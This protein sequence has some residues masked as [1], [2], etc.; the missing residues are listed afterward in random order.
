[1]KKGGGRQK[2]SKFER[3]CAKAIIDTFACKGITAEDCYRTPGSGGHR[4]A[5]KTDP[6]DLV[7]SRR[8][9]KLWPYAVE[10]KFY[11][12]VELRWLMQSNVKEGLFSSWWAQAV[13]ATP[14]D[15]RALLVF[16]QNRD[17]PYAMFAYPKDAVGMDPPIRP[18]IL[19]RVNGQQVYVVRFKS[20]L[21]YY[22]RLHE[23]A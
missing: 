8:L 19:T 16:R 9:A 20:L 17:E 3:D 22:R 1:M 13:A 11:A 15:R 4:F 23:V 7:C 14:K 6:G 5:K 10:C 21:R 18:F 12:K 2:G